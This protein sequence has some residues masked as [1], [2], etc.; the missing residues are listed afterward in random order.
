VANQP[1][2]TAFLYEMF[3][4]GVSRGRFLDFDVD[5]L[6]AADRCDFGYRHL[7]HVGRRAHGVR[8]ELVPRRSPGRRH[9]G[10][11]KNRD[12]GLWLSARA[13]NVPG[14]DLAAK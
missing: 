8:H 1:G 6:H 9:A 3:C 4:G 5:V 14:P 10:I 7:R 13:R 11:K 12:P 2:V